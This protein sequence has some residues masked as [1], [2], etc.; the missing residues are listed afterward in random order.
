M[1]VIDLPVWDQGLENNLHELNRHYEL[2]LCYKKL[3]YNK[4]DFYIRKV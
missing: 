2:E 1:T 3:K 4:S